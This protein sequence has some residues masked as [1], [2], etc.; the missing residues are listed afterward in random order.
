MRCSPE[1]PASGSAARA[2][3]SGAGWRGSA[4]ASTSRSVLARLSVVRA[5]RQSAP[6]SRRQAPTRLNGSPPPSRYAQRRQEPIADERID[7]RHIRRGEATGHPDDGLDLFE[8][9]AAS[10]APFEMVLDAKPLLI[11]D[12]PLEKVTD[13]FDELDAAHLV[14]P[15]SAIAHRRAPSVRSS[16]PGRPARSRAPDGA[17]L[18]PPRTSDREPHE[19]HSTTVLRRR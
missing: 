8:R 3:R 4:V 10:G 2:R 11:A 1:P 5:R 12:V 14:F 6:S 7:A 16:A 15:G 9:R 13:Q 18:V 17:S 19:P